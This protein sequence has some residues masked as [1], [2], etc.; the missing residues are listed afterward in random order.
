ML[1][2]QNFQVKNHVSWVNNII[3]NV[4]ELKCYPSDS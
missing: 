4:D 2:L 1:K 3:M